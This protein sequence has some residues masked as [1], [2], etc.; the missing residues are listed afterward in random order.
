MM[1]LDST[2]RTA[3]IWWSICRPKTGSG[4]GRDRRLA[5]DPTADFH[6][7]QMWRDTAFL[8]STLQFSFWGVEILWGTVWGSAVGRVF[9]FLS[10]RL[11]H[12]DSAVQT[13]ILIRK[14]FWASSMEPAARAAVQTV[15]ALACSPFAVCTGGRKIW[16]TERS[17]NFQRTKIFRGAAVVWDFSSFRGY[18]WGALHRNCKRG[19]SEKNKGFKR[20]PPPNFVIQ[21]LQMKRSSCP[22]KYL[23]LHYSQICDIYIII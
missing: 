16:R 18:Q 1:L 4:V 8:S 15:A 6:L 13:D 11:V 12:R 9:I 19:E 7:F 2:L 17:L 3:C 10:L 14:T 20:H 21:M 5:K 22:S 23:A